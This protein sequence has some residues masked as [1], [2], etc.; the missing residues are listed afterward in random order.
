MLSPLNP[1]VIF[2]L[3]IVRYGMADVSCDTKNAI[4]S[5]YICC[6]ITLLILLA[7]LF[8]DGYF[9]SSS[10][11]M[12]A[13]FF[14]IDLLVA[15]SGTVCVGLIGSLVSSS[16]TISFC[17]VFLICTL[18]GGSFSFLSPNNTSH[19]N[20]MAVNSS[21]E[22]LFGCFLIAS[23][24]CLASSR[25]LSDGVGCGM[26]MVYCLKSTVSDILSAPVYGRMP[27]NVP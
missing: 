8:L 18:L 11:V 22:A 2:L 13:V 20:S 27:L 9:Y 25:I 16:G 12:W 17:F 4:R 3:L 10:F 6:A 19:S 14:C 7:P 21:I 26:A 24:N 23:Y 5:F 1:L 15:F